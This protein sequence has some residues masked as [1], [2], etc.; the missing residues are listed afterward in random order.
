[1]LLADPAVIKGA[2]TALVPSLS[3]LLLVSIGNL[4]WQ[5]ARSSAAATSAN[6]PKLLGTYE[7]PI[8]GS[9]L[10]FYSKRRDML[11][12][13]QQMSKTGN[14]SFNVGQKHIVSVGGVEG[15]RALYESKKLNFAA[16]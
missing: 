7:W 14:F 1:M 8:L 4:V 5:R 6:W 12:E 9:A 13:G 11:V 10:R 15:R 16:G 2:L 3:L